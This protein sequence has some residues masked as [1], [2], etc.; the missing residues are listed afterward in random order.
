[1]LYQWGSKTAKNYFCPKY[2]ILSFRRPSDPTSEE[3]LEGSRPF[4]EWAVNVRYLAGI[5][6]DPI[7]KVYG[8]KIKRTVYSKYSHHDKH[9]TNSLACRSA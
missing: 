3:I 7:K 8:S 9:H 6:L 5:D 4:D 2:G 1:M